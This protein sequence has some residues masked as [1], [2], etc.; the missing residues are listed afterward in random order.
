MDE[1][2]RVN[3]SF[4][5]LRN[6]NTN[7][8]YSSW[9]NIPDDYKVYHLDNCLFFYDSETPSKRP[10]EIMI[11]KKNN[12]K[13]Y[14]QKINEFVSW[15]KNEFKEHLI[16]YF[17]E[18]IKTKKYKC[19]EDSERWYNSFITWKAEMKITYSEMII[20]KIYAMYDVGSTK[21]M[22]EIKITVKENKIISVALFDFGPPWEIKTYTVVY[23]ISESKNIVKRKKYT[24][25]EK[26]H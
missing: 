26:V 3:Y 18:N 22:Y 19:R 2:C 23:R 15:L 16:K 24:A 21:D 25:K 1:N 4:D 6:Q 10:L 17:K 11:H 5:D 9:K 7:Y 20:I 13:N 8:S 12:I 14:I